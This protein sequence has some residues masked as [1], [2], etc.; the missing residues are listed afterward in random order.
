M[1]DD[2]F[3][4][5]F[6]FGNTQTN[7]KR[8]DDDDDIFAT[9]PTATATATPTI[10]NND[11]IKMSSTTK[12]ST[13]GT[14]LTS[15]ASSQN[16]SVDSSSYYKVSSS[17]QGSSNQS[18]VTTNGDDDMEDIFGPSPT[19]VKSSTDNVLANSMNSVPPPADND[20]FHTMD[21][22]A[23]DFLEWLDTDTNKGNKGDTN[24]SSN[25]VKSD[26]DWMDDVIINDTDKTLGTATDGDNQKSMSVVDQP[27]GKQ[28]RMEFVDIDVDMDLARNDLEDT[29]TLDREKKQSLERKESVGTNSSQLSGGNQS[30]GDVSSSSS[31]VKMNDVH[32]DLVNAELSTAVDVATSSTPK[33]TNSPTKSELHDSISADNAGPPS[34]IDASSP[35]IAVIPDAKKSSETSTK[36]TTND[37]DLL[38]EDE[39]PPIS[40]NNIS[41]ALRSRESTMDSHIRQFLYNTTSINSNTPAASEFT[42][43]T[44]ISDD[45]RPWLW[46]KA[47]CGKMLSDVESSSL[48]DSF[49]S[50][51]NGFDLDEFTRLCAGS[52]SES[53]GGST[54]TKENLMLKLVGQFDSSFRNRLLAEVDVLAKRVFVSLESDEP[55]TISSKLSEEEDSKRSVIKKNLCS[56]L[57]FHYRSTMTDTVIETKEEESSQENIGTTEWNSLLGPITATLL[58]ASIPV[59][60][61]SVMLSTIGPASMPLLSLHNKERS[62]VAKSLHSQLYFLAWYHLPLLVLHLDRY[63]PGWHWPKENLAVEK[64]EKEVGDS[65]AENVTKKGRN[66]EANGSIPTSWFTSHLAGECYINHSTEATYEKNGV[67]GA[68]TFMMEPKKLR[69]LWDILLT[70]QDHSLKFFLALA[71]LEKHCDEL[72]M[73]R[74]QELVDE[75]NGIMSFQQVRT[76][77]IDTFVSDGVDGRD[78]NSTE[79]KDFIYEWYENANSLQQSTPVSVL[80][81]LRDAENEAVNQALIERQQLAME[82]MKSRLEA[83]ADAH[84]K[85]AEEEATKREVEA[86]Y[87]TNRKR[88]KA[89]YK[90][91]CPEKLDQVDHILKVYEGRIVLLDMRLQKKYG[92]GFIP[93]VPAFN[94]K[95]KVK[96]KKALSTVGHG[97]QI[98]KKEYM[99]A[100]VESKTKKLIDTNSTSQANH[101]V[102]LKVSASEIMPAIIGE[103]NLQ[104]SSNKH[105]NRLKYYLVDSR[106]DETAKTEGRFPTSVSLSPESLM[107]PDKIKSISDMFE[108][109]RGTVHICVM[110]DGFSE[111]SN[112]YDHSLSD[113]EPALQ[114]DDESRTSLCALFFIKKGFPFVSVLDG[115][116]AAAHAWLSRSHDP[117]SLSSILVDYDEEKS[118]FA[119]LERSYK[120]QQEFANAPARL[121]TIIAAQKVIDASMTRLTLSEQRFEEFTDQLRSQEGRKQVKQSVGKMF[122][123]TVKNKGSDDQ[124]S[125][126]RT[127]SEELEKSKAYDADTNITEGMKQ[128][129]DDQKIPRI[130]VSFGGFKNLG[131]E[132]S[133]VNAKMK[134]AHD[135]KQQRLLEETKQ[136]KPS[137][138]ESNEKKQTE[139]ISVL[140]KVPE[141]KHAPPQ[142]TFDLS[143][144]KFGIGGKKRNPLMKKKTSDDDELVKEIEATLAETGN[145]TYVKPSNKP[146][147]VVAA[148]PTEKPS[149]SMKS[150]PK[151][152]MNMK[153]S[154]FANLGNRQEET[155]NKTRATNPPVSSSSSKEDIDKGKESSSEKEVP[156]HMQM[157]FGRVKLKS[158]PPG[159]EE[160]IMFEDDSD[161]AAQDID[162]IARQNKFSSF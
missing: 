146:A 89:F 96:T 24:A 120:E 2:E 55:T 115:G 85:A 13:S 20:D 4:D 137:S 125:A 46:T 41:E 50:F 135:A 40:F 117:S 145:D 141:M 87:A 140:K 23:R 5:L 131:A 35:T 37:N 119:N 124:E 103:K 80:Q 88:L 113:S 71:I 28:D 150:A 48:C 73:L 25:N 97:I 93:S 74:G 7:T 11:P 114:E 43:F 121:K 22:G 12:P 157:R 106:P 10:L 81:K 16:Q 118:L 110:G 1:S 79:A 31:A 19:T 77:T 90:K 53:K 129:V 49:E 27:K 54:E 136:N 144:I 160:L 102:A 159:E 82:K 94:P 83:E 52:T 112:L 26:D 143:K 104:G 45:D 66:L 56:L 17:N 109:L 91:H 61:T 101:Q 59:S 134:A 138:T 51:Y 70:N 62:S 33:R 39:T 127:K 149:T 86:E 42:T 152:N 108:A 60:V 72:L 116:F 69:A 14:N 63:A 32:E 139:G 78:R 122:K 36:E 128:S 21:E 67:T 8:D 65:D 38:L 142:M 148:K 15:E 154:A 156:L 162:E 100:R 147:K 98:K 130:R 75:L 126:D 105:A 92:V 123:Q 64:E 111:F 99:A 3:D 155:Q 68:R 151:I 57:L 95:L 47:I 6:S 158:G 34:T 153:F 30:S 161:T 44:S 133:K 76:M 29:L 18:S 84:R 107:D 9:S 132:I 58:S